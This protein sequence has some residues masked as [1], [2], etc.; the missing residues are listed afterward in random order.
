MRKQ[1]L[2]VLV[3]LCVTLLAAWGI[4]SRKLESDVLEAFPHGSSREPNRQIRKERLPQFYPDI[5]ENAFLV[6]GD[7]A[8]FISLGMSSNSVREKYGNEVT[9]IVDPQL[10]GM[11]A[12]AVAVY[13]MDNDIDTASIEGELDGGFGPGNIYRI[14]VGDPRFKTDKGIGVGSTL[15]SLRKTYKVDRITAFE[16]LVCVEV[17]EFGASFILK[18]QSPPREF[19][20]TQDMSLIPD[21]MV[22]TEIL[23]TGRPGIMYGN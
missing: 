6:T 19:H 21:E 7:K 4:L 3:V 16:G 11:P 14:T 1:I 8:G 15:G 20:K 23:L 22:I 18:G 9:R 2:L 17:K 5:P 10:E 12:P 13:L